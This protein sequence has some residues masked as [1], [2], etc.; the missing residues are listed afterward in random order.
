MSNIDITN[1]INVSVNTPPAGLGN[2]RVNNLLYIT[3]EAPLSPLTDGYAVYLSPSAVGT[4]FGTT[5]E[6]YYAALAVFSQ[7][8]NILTGGGSL[9]V[10]PIA[11]TGVTLA[12]G[13]TAALGLAPYFGGVVAG[14]AL[15]S[16]EANAASAVAQANSKLLFIGE[17]DDDALVA[18]GWIY[19]NHTSK[20]TYTRPFFHTLGA[21][22][23]RLGAAAYAGAAMSTD[24]SASLTT[25]TMH[26]K[27]LV[28]VDGDTGIDQ[29]LLNKCIAVGA[30]CYPVVKGLP[31]VFSTG[32]NGFFDD[33]YNLNWFKFAQEV[34]L[35]NTLATVGTKI[36]Q[37]EA[38][39]ETIRN[40]AAQ[41]C[42]QAVSNGFI[43]PGSWTS[44]ETFGNPDD[45]RR[46]IE[47]KGYYIYTS[48]VAEQSQADRED[49]IA[50][51]A[52]VAIKYAGAVHKI[53]AIININK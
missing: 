44:A 16:G 41:V 12:Q 9:I 17:N 42:Q 24:F 49:R 46:N 25:R 33:V 39:M 14:F 28:G 21:S 7:S 43:A 29:T 50:P 45:L 47:S 15:G 2:Y 20:Y 51:T 6:T 5:S 53:N 31:K 3:K 30:D 13:I 4:A 38:G 18:L 52:Q 32:A 26:C 35:F 36:P 23:A 34:A 40:S 19:I 27:D 37:T 8:P 11:S 48:P 22:D 10:Y 1:F